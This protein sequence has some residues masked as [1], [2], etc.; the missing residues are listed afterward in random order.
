MANDL[1]DYYDSELGYFRKLGTEFASRHTK[2]AR[3]LRLEADKES[4]DPHV[5]RLIQSVAFIT[6]RIRRKLDDDFPEFI[7]TLLDQIAPHYLT[8]IPSMALLQFVPDPALSKVEEIRRGETLYSRPLGQDVCR[9]RTVYPVKLWP[10]Q[11]AAVEVVPPARAD[12]AD[13]VAAVLRIELRAN[14]KDIQIGSLRLDRLRFYLAGTIQF[15]LYDFLLRHARRVL[16]RAGGTIAAAQMTAVGF[17]DEEALLQESP[18]GL[19]GYRLLQEYFAFPQKFLFL[20]IAGLE[21]NRAC[22]AA[23][24]S[25]EL[26]FLLERRPPP[27]IERELG[28]QNLRLACTPA[29]NLFRKRAEP[30]AID[31]TAFEYLIQPDWQSP[32]AHEVYEVKDVV[33][34]VPHR[35]EETR[36]VL[37]LYGFKQAGTQPEHE[38]DASAYYFLSRREGLQGT[39]VYLSIVDLRMEPTEPAANQVYVEAECSNRDVPH[40]HRNWF[41]GSADFQLEG[42]VGNSVADIGCLEKP[43]AT[44]RLQLGKGTAWRLISHLSLNYLSLTSGPKAL[45]ALQALLR[46]YNFI[47]AA[48]VS[49]HVDGLRAIS[50]RPMVARP[51][52][53]ACSETLGEAV[54][55]CRGLEVTIEI[56]EAFYRDSS[57]LLFAGVLERFFRHYVSINSFVKL[58][59]RN[60]QGEV[61]KQWPPRSGTQLLG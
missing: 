49:R 14:S 16:C 15:Q 30:I 59:A 2:N 9:F 28:P 18:A 43:T 5:E 31:E 60:R 25:L 17:E 26:L 19:S 23:T 35:P 38:A 27:S 6:A 1:Y 10:F 44:R 12:I 33:S 45:P 8:P 32:N 39:D 55:Y 47:D 61:I 11:V 42:E 50:A 24:G 41:T 52:L 20:D 13:D 46:L 58:I 54:G 37:P 22:V 29:I 3:Y 21:A 56:D 51:R 48:E 7:H 53:G 4:P 57:A 34:F 36:T 40:N